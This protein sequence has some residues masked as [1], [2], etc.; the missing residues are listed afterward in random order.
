MIVEQEFANKINEYFCEKIESGIHSVDVVDC[1]A[2][3]CEILNDC[4]AFEV[5]NIAKHYGLINQL[6]QTQ[7]EC[8]ELVQAISKYFRNKDIAGVIEEIA[9]IE[10][11]TSQIKYLMKIEQAV[12]DMKTFKL[13]RQLGRIEDE[14][15]K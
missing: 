14:K 11:M 12:V 13:E 10:I 6:H 9:D 7:E 15:T 1:N 3:I 8:G 5:Q 4:R 2:D